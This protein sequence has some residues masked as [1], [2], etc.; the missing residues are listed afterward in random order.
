MSWWR[1]AADQG[2]A[3]AQFNLGEFYGLGRGTKRDYKQ[4]LNWFFKAA[5]QGEPDA[6]YHLGLMYEASNG[7]PSD[8]NEALRWFR[9]SGAQGFSDAR[10]K[11]DAYAKLFPPQHEFSLGSSRRSALIKHL[12]KWLTSI[13]FNP[14]TERCQYPPNAA[15]T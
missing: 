1:K 12:K 5:E 14:P 13:R 7:V 6:Q 4:A 9:L 15:Q 3:D 2:S 8:T 10:E 11:V